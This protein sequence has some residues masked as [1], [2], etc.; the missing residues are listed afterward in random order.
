MIKKLFILFIFLSN[1]SFGQNDKIKESN[2]DYSDLAYID[3]QK[4]YLSIVENG[5]ENKEVYEKLGDTY[6][7]NNDYTN[8]NT[9]YSKLFNYDAESID[10]NYF[11]KYIQT[12]K[13]IK[14]YD[15]VNEILAIYKEAKGEDQYFENYL[16]KPNYLEMIKRQ[17]GR[18]EIKNLEINSAVQDF[19]TSYLPL[20]NHVVYASSK[21]TSSFTKRLHKWNDRTF[22]NLY[23][24]NSD[25]AS[26]ELTNSI[27]FD[28]AI[29]TKFHESNAVFTK[30]GKTMYF[31]RNNYTKLKSNRKSD[32]VNR[33]KILMATRLT[34]TSPW[35]NILELPFNSDDF[36]TAHPALSNDEKT[37]FFA[38]DRPGSIKDDD[39]NLTSDI[40]YVSIDEMN[41]FSEPIN[42]KSINTVGNDLFP[43]VSDNGDFY[44]SSN[45]YQGLGALDIYVVKTN[46]KGLPI[47]NAVNIGKPINSSYDDFA[48]IIKDS[49]KTGY[50]SS[51]RKSGKG[52]DDI[53][54]FKQL[55]DL[56]C[57]IDVDGVVTNKENGELVPFAKVTL[58]DKDNNKLNSLTVGEDAAY[59][60][61][62]ECAQNY[63]IR[64]EKENFTITEEFIQ[65][66]NV[67]STINQPLILAKTIKDKLSGLTIGDDLNDILDLNMIYFD[68]DK[69]NIRYDAQIEL[70]KVYEF[71]K[72]YPNS[73]ID[74]RSHTDSRAS[75]GYNIKLSDRRAKSTRAYLI[76]KG[77]NANR[78]TA[79][80][81]G[82]YQLVNECSN[83]VECTDEQHQLNRRSEFIIM[84]IK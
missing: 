72:A 77:V 84:K 15:R 83:G 73:V 82:E 53:Y 49:L 16:N 36:S 4:I 79:R 6:Y 44:F 64:A 66:P 50:F 2:Q 1:F 42:L 21:D 28:R 13:S 57:I 45:G 24:A 81:Y 19:G 58:L 69:H 31:T 10:R 80:G 39:N 18:Y 68:F 65:T 5:Y 67:S 46:Y 43:F 27:K 41:G 52:L 17:S 30:D 61:V 7:Y 3:A 74:I 59:S 56:K 35:G 63:S 40:W 48:F 75:D 37:L 70:Q 51:N 76:R 12:L 55:K 34:T 9:W 20:S 29:S 78:L 8:A 22:L 26:L 62:L 33:L 14:D 71:M 25:S 54:S 11:F 47:N 32:Q 60:F 38:S 23:K